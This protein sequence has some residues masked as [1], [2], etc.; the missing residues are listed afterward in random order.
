MNHA[1]GTTRVKK[2]LEQTLAC[3]II[4]F[5]GNG[6]SGGDHLRL[7]LGC[8]IGL[9]RVTGIRV[10]GCNSVFIRRGFIIRD[11]RRK[12][13]REIMNVFSG[14]T[15]LWFKLNLKGVLKEEGFMVVFNKSSK[16]IA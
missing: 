8:R 1:V 3:L 13:R 12:Q 6:N 11:L 2:A 15:N 4:D 5:A 9:L 14:I 7:F 16:A 10:I